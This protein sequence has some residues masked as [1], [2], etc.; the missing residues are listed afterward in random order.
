MFPV[1]LIRY[2]KEQLAAAIPNA[3]VLFPNLSLTFSRGGKVVAQ[4]VCLREGEF[5]ESPN[6]EVFNILR[7][8]GQPYYSDPNPLTYFDSYTVSIVLFCALP[9]ASFPAQ[10]VLS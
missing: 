4:K 1:A 5:G 8:Y 2:G 7:A 9:F 6:D 10:V 3:T